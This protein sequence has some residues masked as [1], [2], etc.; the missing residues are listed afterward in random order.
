MNTMTNCRVAGAWRLLA[1][2][3]LAILFAGL[4]AAPASARNVP[5]SAG[6]VQPQIDKQV[7]S[8][9]IDT[10]LL[11]ALDAGT[12][13][14]TLWRQPVPGEAQN[15]PCEWGL[16]FGA[17]A[18][19]I[20]G[21]PNGLDFDFTSVFGSAVL[22]RHISPSTVLI[23]A[24]LA[25]GGGGDLDYNNGELK[26]I[27]VGGAL[28]ALIRLNAIFDLSLLGGAEWLNYK[29]ERSNGLF[30]GDYDAVRLFLDG[31]IKG[32]QDGEFGFIEYGG[33][34]RLIYQR[35]DGY[36]EKS[37]GVGT[38]QVGSTD[39]TVLTALA[40]VKLGTPIGIFTP[41]IQATGYFDIL[42]DVDL[43]GI[44]S[45]FETSD[46]KIRGRFGIG[47]NMFAFPGG[48]LNLTSGVHVDRDGFAGVDGA[49]RFILVF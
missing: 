9:L 37:G 17:G 42:D 12:C 25:E 23:A 31:Q 5:G 13:L 6:V 1:F 15:Q 35:N 2:V 38:S 41:Y 30:E 36:T 3:W 24:I 4:S 28:G 10:T 34:L 18:R 27:G 32:R 21:S 8:A 33:G 14:N 7:A 39:F 46:G 43:P 48:T 22:S 20:I 11:T 49:V 19:H 16:A 47:V 26:N 45:P 40:D 29:T 44:L